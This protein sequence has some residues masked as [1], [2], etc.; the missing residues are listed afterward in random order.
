VGDLVHKVARVGQVGGDGHAHAQGEHVL[1]VV[2][3]AL[4]QGLGEGVEGAHEVGLVLLLEADAATHGVGG[5]VLED[6]AS[7][8]VGHV[9]AAGLA[10]VAQGQ[11]PGHVCA[12]RLKPVALAPVHV[13]TTGDAGGVE[14]VGGLDAVELRLELGALLQAEVSV[15]PVRPLR[16]QQLPE[17]P[18]D[19][20]AAPHHEVPRPR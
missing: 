8:E 15:A 6:A 13:R 17:Q 18:A 10:G 14:D 7:G 12:D 2:H 20:P 16:L 19:P 9:D 11:H 4:H 5:V 3:E 1:V